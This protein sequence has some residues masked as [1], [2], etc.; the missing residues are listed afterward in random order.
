MRSPRHR[1]GCSNSI[2][3]RSSLPFVH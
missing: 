2:H 1:T 3:L